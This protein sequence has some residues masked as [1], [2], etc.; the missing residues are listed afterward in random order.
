MSSCAC[1]DVEQGA[2]DAKENTAKGRSLTSTGTFKNPAKPD[3]LK[4]TAEVRI[5][6]NNVP[7]YHGNQVQVRRQL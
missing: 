1:A 5:P 4:T 6:G 7:K 2:H 3:V